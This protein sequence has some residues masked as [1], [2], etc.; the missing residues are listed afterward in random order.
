MVNSVFLTIF[1]RVIFFLACSYFFLIMIKINNHVY[2]LSTG[3]DPN[4]GRYYSNK[5][6]LVC[7]ST[8]GASSFCRIVFVLP[9][10]RRQRLDTKERT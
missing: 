9:L 1:G 6:L 7:F 3:T 2:T 10:T 4:Q 8:V 5:E